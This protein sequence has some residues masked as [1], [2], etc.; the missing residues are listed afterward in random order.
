MLQKI[1]YFW[2]ETNTKETKTSIFPQWPPNCVEM[3]YTEKLQ[4]D[5]Q[6]LEKD[7]AKLIEIKSNTVQNIIAMV[8]KN[9]SGD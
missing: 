8:D 2:I 4:V 1:F 6:K 3:T 9:V 7:T 5:N